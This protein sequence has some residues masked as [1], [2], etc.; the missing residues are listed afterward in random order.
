VTVIFYCLLLSL[1][2]NSD[3]IRAVPL[4]AGAL[5]IISVLANRIFSGVSLLKNTFQARASLPPFLILFVF[6]SQIEP[7][8]L[9]ASSQSRADVIAISLSAVLCLTG[10]QWLSLKPK[11]P[12]SV[13]LEGEPVNYFREKMPP[14][15]VEDLEA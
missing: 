3:I 2:D 10:L 12:K 8:L 14:A 13:E 9:A 6:Y 4:A 15:A 5:G 11:V 1:Q 7:A